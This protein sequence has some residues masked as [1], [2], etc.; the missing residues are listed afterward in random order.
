M[1]KLSS[2]TKLLMV[3]LL[4]VMGWSLYAYIYYLTYG[5]GVTGMNHLVLRG[6]YIVNF[7]F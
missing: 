3:F 6:I 2:E 4:G 1:G 7:V 5:L